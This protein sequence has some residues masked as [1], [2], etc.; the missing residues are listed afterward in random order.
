MIKSLDVS[1]AS[2]PDGFSALILKSVVDAIFLN[3]AF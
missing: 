3:K 2:G 1:K